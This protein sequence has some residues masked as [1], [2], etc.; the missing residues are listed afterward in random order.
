MQRQEPLEIDP[1]TILT[2]HLLT[3]DSRSEQERESLKCDARTQGIYLS[4]LK[5]KRGEHLLVLEGSFHLTLFLE[6][7]LS[8][9]SSDHC[10]T[11]SLFNQILPMGQENCEKLWNALNVCLKFF[12]L[13]KAA[14]VDFASFPKSLLLVEHTSAMQA[15]SERTRW[16]VRIGTNNAKNANKLQKMDDNDTSTPQSIGIWQS[17]NWTWPAISKARTCKCCPV[18]LHNQRLIFHDFSGFSEIT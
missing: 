17:K 3:C 7:K 14:S 6:W 10:I 13:C 5:W 15:L 1:E 8:A 4:Q 18:K 16:Q 2:V 9:L 12:P 11:W